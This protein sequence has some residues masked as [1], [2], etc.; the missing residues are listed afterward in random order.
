MVGSDQVWRY[1]YLSRYIQNYYLDFA[2]EESKKISYAASF[3][4][5]QTEYPASV[6][7]Q[8]KRLAERFD[9]ISVREDS[10][11]AICE[12]YFNKKA[13]HVIDPTFLLT[14][15]EYKK[16]IGFDTTQ[17]K[18]LQTYILDESEEKRKVIEHIAS[19]H[20]YDR[21]DLMPSEHNGLRRFPSVSRW[22][23]SL[24][25]ARFVITDSFHGTAFA[26]LFNTEFVVM[27]NPERGNARLLSLLKMFNLEKR[28]IS[29]PR[30]YET[31][32]SNRIDWQE[33]NQKIDSYRDFA[34]SY[35]TESLK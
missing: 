2:S 9:A 25:N 5:D 19:Q 27:A 32:A 30:E 34:R 13:V 31:A 11:V 33:V 12:K 4:I 28:L 26:I 21:N 22:L 29:T 23:E 7:C 35:I 17:V 20:G 3:G 16:Q 6:I 15:A 10:G 24:Y 18:T 14:P 1:A 8:C